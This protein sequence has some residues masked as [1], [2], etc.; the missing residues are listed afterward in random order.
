MALS[1]D[2]ARRILAL[3]V[4][5]DVHARHEYL[6]RQANHGKLTNEEQDEF[7]VLLKS[8][9]LLSDLKAKAREF[10]EKR[11]RDGKPPTS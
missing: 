11:G 10:L 5:P 9:G 8:K 3:D 1:E 7:D 4:G 2:E 6:S